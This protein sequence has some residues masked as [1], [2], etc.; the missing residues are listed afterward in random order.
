VFVTGAREFLIDDLT[1]AVQNKLQQLKT[2]HVG[3]QRLEEMFKLIRRIS[4]GVIPRPDRPWEEDRKSPENFYLTHHSNMI[5]ISFR[6][7]FGFR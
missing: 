3:I 7:A 2:Q 4:Y 6:V 1:R 5:Y